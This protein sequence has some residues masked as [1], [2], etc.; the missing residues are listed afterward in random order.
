MKHI[1]PMTA[2]TCTGPLDCLENII[3]NF[4]GN[5]IPAKGHEKCWGDEHANVPGIGCFHLEDI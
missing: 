4:I 5:L 3:L 2:D 1:R